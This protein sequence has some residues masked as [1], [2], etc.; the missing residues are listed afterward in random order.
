MAEAKKTRKKAEK[1]DGKLLQ[2]IAER[3]SS[4]PIYRQVKKRVALAARELVSIENK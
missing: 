3:L 2:E 4:D 1:K